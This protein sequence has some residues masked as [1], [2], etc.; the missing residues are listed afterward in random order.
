MVVAAGRID[1]EYLRPD[2]HQKHFVISDMAKQLAL[3]EI[4]GGGPCAAGPLE[5]D[6][7]RGR[8]APAWHDSAADHRR[9]N[10]RKEVP[11]LC[12][13]VS[14]S[15]AQAQGYRHDRQPAGA[16]GGRCSRGHRGA[17]RNASLSAK[18]SPD[19]NPIEMSFSKLKADLRKA[20]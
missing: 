20:A 8:A 16:Q 3:G 18:Y 17:R 14:C 4:G 15:D 10:D 9:L 13:T 19:L 7:L 6:H 11:G 1:S 2:L 5:D 12:R